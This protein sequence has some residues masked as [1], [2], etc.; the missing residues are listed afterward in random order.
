MAML[1][2]SI[3][4]KECSAAKA[5]RPS[6]DMPDGKGERADGEVGISH[7]NGYRP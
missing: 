7:H 2:A 5:A 3:S 4:S 1:V 6:K